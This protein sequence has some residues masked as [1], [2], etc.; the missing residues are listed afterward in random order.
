MLFTDGCRFVCCFSI[1]G[2]CSIIWL[3]VQVGR[4][5]WIVGVFV[6]ESGEGFCHIP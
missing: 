1:L 2:L 6:T 5:L 3:D 4:I